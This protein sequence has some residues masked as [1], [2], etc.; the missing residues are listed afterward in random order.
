VKQ[1]KIKVD[2]TPDIYN[3]NRDKVMSILSEV[4]FSPNTVTIKIEPMYWNWGNDDMRELRISIKVDAPN[5][6]TYEKL[7]KIEDILNVLKTQNN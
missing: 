4:F 7:Q 2:T 3:K 6:S 1:I 5:M